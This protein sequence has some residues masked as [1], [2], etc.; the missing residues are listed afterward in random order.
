[1]AKSNASA[2]FVL[3]FLGSLIYLGIIALMGTSFS[4]IL[5]GYGS[6]WTPLLYGTA[7]LASIALF[8]T[9]FANFSRMGEFL[10]KYAFCETAIAAFALFI[11]TAGVYSNIWFGSAI[12]GFI[13]GMIGAGM[14]GLGFGKK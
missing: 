3:Q 7:V 11:L 2:V 9:S 8:I 5:N 4:T 12:V 14:S 1:M 10:G 6:L 13:L